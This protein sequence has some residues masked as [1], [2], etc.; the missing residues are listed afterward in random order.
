[1]NHTYNGPRPIEEGSPSGDE[2]VARLLQIAGHRPAIPAADAARVKA[3]AHAE[4][5]QVVWANR[6]RKL[7][8]VRGVGGFLAAAAA[9]LLALN[10]NFTDNLRRS[11]TQPVAE[12]VAAMGR[13]N[14]L[15]YATKLW[16]GDFAETRVEGAAG[17][18]R[19]ALKM[20]SEASVRLDVDTRL[21]MMSP[22]ELQLERGAVYVDSQGSTL[23][24]RTALGVITNIGTQ[25]EVRLAPDNSN[26]RIRVR[27]GEVSLLD[28]RGQSHRVRTDEELIATA[29]GTVEQNQLSSCDPVWEWVR[30]VRNPFEGTTI[31][32]LLT[33]AAAESGWKLG[34]RLDATT[35]AVKVH[36]DD[37]TGLSLED[38]LGIWLPS[39]GL[40]FEIEN[41]V[42]VVEPAK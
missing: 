13:T 39:S 29:E 1:M 7:Y 21:M 11:F 16:T 41:C 24:V 26:V 8:L 40:S 33:W 20:A 38:V 18:Q 36:G 25:F 10:T 34:G 12:V 6:R 30:T 42:L 19:L 37:I 27:E 5:Q 32:E 28:N 31:R 35:A 3:A 15:E 2:T 17:P 23:E 4:W 14:E 9:V 22:S